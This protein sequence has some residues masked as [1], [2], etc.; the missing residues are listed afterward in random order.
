MELRICETIIW[1]WQG[2]VFS[3]TFDGLYFISDILSI[4]IPTLLCVAISLYAKNMECCQ[5][6]V[7]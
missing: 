3:C 6:L 5:I 7:Y 4:P 2:V 1:W